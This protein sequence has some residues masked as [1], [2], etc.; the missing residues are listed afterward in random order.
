M[1]VWNDKPHGL[2]LDARHARVDVNQFRGKADFIIGYM[3]TGSQMEARFT[4]HIQ[5]AYDAGIPMLGLY[6]LDPELYYD[7]GINLARWPQ[8]ID[9]PQMKIIER[10]LVSGTVRR[11]VHGLILDCT[12]YMNVDGRTQATDNWVKAVARHML[13]QVWDR[14][15]LPV[16]LYVTMRLVNAY[17]GSDILP[18]YLYGQGEICSWKNAYTPA[19]GDPQPANWSNFPVPADNYLPEF[20]Y[21]ERVAFFQYSQTKWRLPGIADSANQGIAV[22]LWMYNGSRK[23]LHEALNFT[24]TSSG[25]QYTA[26]GGTPPGGNTSPGSGTGTGPGT[27]PGATAPV[28]SSSTDAYLARI[29]SALE[30][31]ANKIGA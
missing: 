8:G 17:E 10:Q 16:W 30:R 26:P 24:A 31:I 14:Y 9:D 5:Q 3:G 29:A 1:G 13:A 15:K 20:V 11:V 2:G 23:Q 7:M 19:A 4:D 6:R 27:A 21:A 25:S 22:P 28:P 12:K 18:V